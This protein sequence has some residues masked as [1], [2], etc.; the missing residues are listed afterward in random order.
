MLNREMAKPAQNSEVKRIGK[1]GAVG[2][3][4]TA[5]D[6]TIYNL[7]SSKTAL[8]LI[9]SNLISTTCAMIFSFFANK[10][11]V[12]ESR[13]GNPYKEALIFFAVTAF[14]LYVLQNGVIHLLTVNWLGPVHLATSI[15]HTLGL[16]SKLSDSFVIKNSAKAAG[17]VLSL[18]W[19]Y[20][21]YKNGC[22][23]NETRP[24][25]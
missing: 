23:L 17:I 18:T 5:I 21:T 2:I 1:F 16:G 7:L 22:L 20:L 9:Q 13:R 3:I 6:F 24:A 10:T 15:I 4:N 8:T 19:N 11:V 12:F 14:G 25:N